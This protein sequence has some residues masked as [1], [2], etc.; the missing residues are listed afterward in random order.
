LVEIVPEAATGDEAGAKKAKSKE[1]KK[2]SAKAIPA[3]I[4]NATLSV[5][6]MVA[7]RSI[8]P[9]SDA[10]SPI[11][12][13]KNID[14]ASQVAHAISTNKVNMEFD[15]YTADRLIFARTTTRVPTCLEPSNSTPACF[16]R[17][18][19]LDIRQLLAN[20]GDDREL[21]CRA[22]L[23]LHECWQ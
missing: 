15:F 13:K 9:S 1:A 5:F 6:L 20:L 4:K 11:C 3:E 17:Y 21:A 14:A 22:S 12:R 7:V 8:S 18:A 2:E 19:N 16:Y 23:W 10:C